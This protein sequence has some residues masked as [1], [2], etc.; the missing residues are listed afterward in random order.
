MADIKQILTAA[1]DATLAAELLK[2]Y[3]EVI[4]NFAL[5]KWKYS[6]LE[7][8]HFVE[9]ARRFIELKLFGRYTPIGQNLPSFNDPELQ[10]YQNVTGD[11]SYRVI[12]PRVLFSVFTIRNKRGVG[13][14]GPVSPNEMDATFALSGTKW[15]LAEL[16]RLNSNLPISETLELISRIVERRLDLLWKDGDTVRILDHKMPAPDKVL[17]HLYD[18]SPQTRAE[19]QAAIE[20]KNSS[21][22]LKV[23]KRLHATRHTDLSADGTCK[24]TTK[25]ILAAEEIVRASAAKSTGGEE[26]KVKRRRRGR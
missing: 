26:P 7:T 6:E 11:E 1:S 17:V 12:I 19:L 10:R 22:F 13:H 4:E 23:L 25:G 18:K 3:G 16:V 20:Y 9:S 8:G 21:D 24:I 2:A 14:V 15:T 5:R